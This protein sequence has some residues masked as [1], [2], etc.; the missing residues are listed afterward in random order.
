MKKTIAIDIDRVLRRTD[1]LLGV[2]QKKFKEPLEAY[3]CV[4][5]TEIYLKNILKYNYP[6][7]EEEVAP[8][9]EDAEKILKIMEIDKK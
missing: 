8:L 1:Y 2:L 4:K 9:I 5:Y 3:L 6:E 7:L